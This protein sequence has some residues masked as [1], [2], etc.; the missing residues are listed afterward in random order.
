MRSPST[1]FLRTCLL[2]LLL[3]AVLLWSGCDSGGSEP[4]GELM[5]QNIVAGAGLAAEPGHG[6]MVRY[7]GM[8][9]DGTVFDSSTN[10]P[11]SI[12]AF[13]L[14][15]G[16]VLKGWDEGLVGLRVGGKRRLT[17]PPHLA[18]GSRGITDR[19]PA[20]A[21]VI[22]EIELVHILEEVLVRDL[23]VGTGPAVEAGHEVLIEYIGT[24][25]NGSVFSA[26]Q[27]ESGP[28]RFLIG[29]GEVVLGVESGMLGMRVGG[30]RNLTI[31][32]QMAYGPNATGAIPPYAVLFFQIELLEIR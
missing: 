18:Y 11:D 28:F 32:S 24:L 15:V 26:T 19:V 1:R 27:F 31:P 4:E 14:G 25:S 21:T 10:S 23:V 30:K 7:T 6:I 8:L 3:P 29:G 17:I 13:T 9:E 20:N 16:Q 2:S 5:V 22:F 12:F